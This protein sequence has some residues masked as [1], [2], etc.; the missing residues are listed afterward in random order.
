MNKRERNLLTFTGICFYLRTVNKTQLID[1]LQSGLEDL[2]RKLV[3]K[4]RVISSSCT[5]KLR[6][7]FIFNNTISGTNRSEMFARFVGHKILI[8]DHAFTFEYWSLKPASFLIEKHNYYGSALD[9]IR[10]A[11]CLWFSLIGTLLV[12]FTIIIAQCYYCIKDT[13][14]KPPLLHLNRYSA[15]EMPKFLRNDHN[16]QENIRTLPTVY[17]NP[18]LLTTGT[19][20]GELQSSKPDLYSGIDASKTPWSTNVDRKENNHGQEINY[21]TVNKSMKPKISEHTTNYCQ[22]SEISNSQ[23]C[24]EFDNT[25]L[26]ETNENTIFDIERPLD[27]EEIPTVNGDYDFVADESDDGRSISWPSVD[28]PCM[29]TRV[30]YSG[31][32]LGMYGLE[33]DM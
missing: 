8:N 16:S 28:T 13:L 31:D 21:A 9:S 1:K 17:V 7:T 30:T 33:T 24:L 27:I 20:S 23:H 11:Q 4:F 5:E 18:L 15:D 32:S 19:S 22:S 25:M 26:E 10:L 29:M 14:I 6:V 12:V 3:P 2:S